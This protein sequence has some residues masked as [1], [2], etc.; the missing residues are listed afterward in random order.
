MNH[1]LSQIIRRRSPRRSRL[2][3]RGAVLV[4]VLVFVV[5][6][7]LG[8]Y[9]FSHL[10]IVERQATRLHTQRIQ[11]R[12]LADSGLELIKTLV[13]KD[14]EVLREEGGLYANPTYFQA[15][16]VVD[17]PKLG[18]GRFS[19]VSTALNEDGVLEGIRFGLENES[20][21]LNLNIL[22]F[23]EQMQEDG[24]VN[25]LM[26][27]PGMTEEIADAILD[28]ID[29][30]DEARELGAEID[31]YSGLDP[32]YAPKNG[33]LDSVEELLLVRGVTVGLMF[34]ADANRNSLLDAHEADGE[35]IDG[36]DNS[37]GALSQGWANYLTLHSMEANLT[38]DGSPRI[39][40][41]GEDLEQLHEDLEDVLND[42]W[43][44]FI[45]A[46]RQGGPHS[47]S[48]PPQSIGGAKLDYNQSAKYQFQTI[49]DL[50]GED[51]QARVAGE[52]QPI[53]LKSPFPDSPLLMNSFLPI[54]ADYVTVN[55]SPIV[56]GR[57]NINQAPKAILLGIPGFDETIVDKLLSVRESE[58]PDDKT[59]RRHETWLVGEAIVTLDEMKQ[60][61][62]FVTAGGSAYRA[63]IVGYF[64]QG[65]PS[66]RIEVIV[67][68]T[69]EAPSVLLWRNLSHLGRGWAVE[70]LGVE[71]LDE[72]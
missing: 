5:I 58:T 20:A 12:A 36:V 60:L 64:E 68:A 3:R 52:D 16:L 45:V 6:L 22:P 28:W 19:V 39:D 56:P 4:V 69:A 67:D 43:A 65:G 1:A 35:S 66:A 7:S 70:T 72:T 31:Y 59:H 21:R 32:P 23:A 49:L 13:V 29:D 42:E 54:L 37:D 11:A 27:L 9:S 30:D 47:G 26:A 48:D 25:L 40:L 41:N 24:G 2:D 71:A 55:P 38:P 51:T 33:P 14:V 61:M 62:P 15:Q 50:V 10:M 63:Q 46:F 44:T 17:D 18:R 8:A 57:I 53:V 34:G